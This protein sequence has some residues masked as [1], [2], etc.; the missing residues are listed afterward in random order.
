M[1]KI[2]VII[3]TDPG[4]DDVVAIMCAVASGR[5][6]IKGITCVPG[7]G[8]LDAVTD[9]ILKVLDYLGITDIPVVRGIAKPFRGPCKHPVRVHGYT[10]LDGPLFP[11]AKQK[12]L[13]MNVCDFYKKV[14]TE[15]NEKITIIALGP[16]TNVGT[17]L[18]S[19]PEIISNI[20]RIAL[21]GGSA[22]GGNVN[23]SAEFNFWHDPE[24]AA[25][26]FQSGIRILMCGLDVTLKANLTLD[27]IE[28]IRAIG[29]KGSELMVNMFDYYKMNR[30]AD[31]FQNV[32]PHDATVIAWLLDPT[33][34]FTKPYLVEVDVYGEYT[35]GCSVTHV[36]G[37][38][39]K[40]KMK[41]PPN[42]DVA[43]GCDRERFVNMIK[44][45]AR[46]F[47]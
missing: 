37:F 21:M 32:L 17:A 46:W 12:P 15:S 19:E 26:V 23:G 9:N 30:K 34:I 43:Y 41:Y 10:G 44:D 2:P 29:T 47:R 28:E 8:P 40:D 1:N 25:V 33:M 4:H 38:K 36:S 13:D 6:D 7:N 45:A 31:G 16:L 42:T 18:L 39:A 27:E 11:K 20:E 14:I 35:R 24:S 22:A 5:F 3:D